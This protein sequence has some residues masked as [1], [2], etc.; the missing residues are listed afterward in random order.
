MGA[1]SLRTI[2][3]TA[4]ILAATLALASAATGGGEQKDS[5]VKLSATASALGADGKQTITIK[6]AINEGWYAYAN[7]VGWDE[8]ESTQTVVKVESANKLQKVALTYPKGVEKS[9]MG[10]KYFTYKGTLEI[11]ADVE[12]AAGDK[13][14]LHVTV[15]YQTCSERGFCLL[16]ESVK[17]DLK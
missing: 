15:R 9:E 13:G 5:Q 14:P 17:L 7:P 8:F 2:G 12:R 10:H 3:M 11:K 16:P 4:A 6:M 1:L